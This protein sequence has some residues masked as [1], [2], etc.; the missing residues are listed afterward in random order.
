MHVRVWRH[1]A[2]SGAVVGTA[3]RSNRPS[4]SSGGSS[5]RRT[6]GRGAARTSTEV[7]TRVER[8][9]LIQRTRYARMRGDVWN[10]CVAGRWLDRGAGL[11]ASARELLVTA[12]ERLRISARGYHRVLRVG[13][14]IADLDGVTSIEASHIAEALRYRPGDASAGAQVS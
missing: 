14:T 1:S 11:T 4:R 8:A 3:R 6:W 9:R 10:G 12:A 7:R 13:R 5:T 2:L